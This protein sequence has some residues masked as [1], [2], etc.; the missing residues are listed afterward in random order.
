MKKS[1]IAKIAQLET[2]YV[3]ETPFKSREKDRGNKYFIVFYDTNKVVASFKTQK[4]L[5]EKIDDIF[6]NGQSDGDRL[7][8]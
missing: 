3:T 2:M 5:E 7:F 8:F 4:D 6:A 1:L